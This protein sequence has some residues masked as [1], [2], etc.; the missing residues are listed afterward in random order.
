MNKSLA[1]FLDLYNELDLKLK[2][3][4]RESASIMAYAKNATMLCEEYINCLKNDVIE[5]GFKDEASEIRFFKNVKPKFL[6]LQIYF[7]EL[8]KFHQGLPAEYSNAT[9]E[10]V[11]EKTKEIN[12]FFEC[13]HEFYRYYYVCKWDFSDK[14]Y[15]LRSEFDVSL[16]PDISYLETDYQFRTSYDFLCSR[17][18]GYHRVLKYMQDFITVS[19]QPAAEAQP[20]KAVEYKKLVWTENA[21]ALDEL[22]Y[23]LTYSGAVNHGKASAIDIR[24]ALGTLFSCAPGDFYDSGYNIRQRKDKKDKFLQKLREGF[25][26]WFEEKI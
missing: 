11:S 15:F 5:T 18:L 1:E 4:E 23:A 9:A 2:E 25:I 3:L 19:I 20:S 8:L 21:S 13:N 12:K 14:R 17:I 26:K 16:N 7:V 10:Y 6:G 22:T 24:K